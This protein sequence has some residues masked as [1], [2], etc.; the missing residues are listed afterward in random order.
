MS[1]VKTACAVIKMVALP[2]RI[3][4]VSVWAS[5]QCRWPPGQL[6]VSRLRRRCRQSR[7]PTNSLPTTGPSSTSSFSYRCMPRASRYT[8][9][10]ASLWYSIPRRW[11]TTAIDR[12]H[13]LL[14][15]MVLFCHTESP[16]FIWYSFPTLLTVGG[17]GSWSHT[18]VAY[19]KMVNHPSTNE[20]QISV[21]LLPLPLCQTTVWTW[22]IMTCSTGQLLYHTH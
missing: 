6:G 22:M 14:T 10:S 18:E 16:H 8:L 4:W 17:L 7:R 20:A 1:G 13:L 2:W 21:T 3:W 11:G 12:P 19:S 5:G 15:D 9:Y